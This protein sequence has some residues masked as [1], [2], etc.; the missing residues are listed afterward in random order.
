LAQLWMQS[1]HQRLFETLQ[2]AHASIPR[3]SAVSEMFHQFLLMSLHV[4][5]D[6]VM[7]FAGK[8]GEEEAHQ[9]YRE[10]QLWS[11]NKNA[12]TAIWY[13]G[14]VVRAV[15]EVPPFQLRGADSFLTYHAIMVL[16]TYGMMLRDATRR[17]GTT[18]PTRGKSMKSIS[19]VISTTNVS[20]SLIDE[21]PVV[22]LNGPVTVQS[23]AFIRTNIGRPCLQLPSLYDSPNSSTNG[24]AEHPQNLVCELAN[25]QT[26]MKAG[27]MI[28]QSNYPEEVRK[29]RNKLPPMSR[30]LCDLMS[31]LGGLR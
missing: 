2:N 9:A 25:P 17:T 4:N 26:V 27:I 24:Q 18:T 14:Q 29:H 30:S 22:M 15:V 10:L 5:V 3:S 12:R 16:W 20:V 21:R 6:S 1:R 23:E 28:I 19:S 7:R 31:E 11:K 13:A 8:C